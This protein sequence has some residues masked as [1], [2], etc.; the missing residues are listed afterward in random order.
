[1]TS[2]SFSRWQ[3]RQRNTTSGFVLMM[4]LSSE[5][6]H[7]SS[8]QISSSHL[9][10]RLRYNYFRF[11]IRTVR[12][13]GILLPISHL[14]TSL[15]SDARVY[16]QTKFHSYNSIRGWGITISGLQ[17]QTCAILEF[18][19]WIRFRPYHRSQ[20]VIVHQSGECHPNR[21][22]HGRIMTS[23]RFS[24]RRIL[25]FRGPIMGSLKSPLS[26]FL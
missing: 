22:A 17:K 15:S 13:T 23:R 5:G 25:D 9:N 1:M 12:N 4:S 11:G 2:Y 20:H 18:Y 24:K 10:P 7:L 26:D 3:P 6:Q 19:F 14:V 21:T 8:N 16:Q